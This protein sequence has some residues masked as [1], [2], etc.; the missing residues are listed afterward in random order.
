MLQF[1]SIISLTTC[2][3]VR[4]NIIIVYHFFFGYDRTDNGFELPKLR[5]RINC[6]KKSILQGSPCEF[7]NN[8]CGFFG[9]QA[10]VGARLMIRIKND[11]KIKPAVRGFFYFSERF[12]TFKEVVF[13]FI[14]YSFT[15]RQFIICFRGGKFFVKSLFFF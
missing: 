13:F 7:R 4:S 1:G 12:T 8:F 10:H 2:I 5:F 14:I 6:S 9:K 11:G 3:P 15:V